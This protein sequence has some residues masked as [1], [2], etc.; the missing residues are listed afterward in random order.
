MSGPDFE[1]ARRYALDRLE[2]ELAATLVYHSLAHTR[3]EV[4]PA[5]EWLAALEGVA[6]EPLL[7][8]LT[9]AYYHDLG[10]VERR[11]GHEAAGARIASQALPAFGYSPAQ[12]RAIAA[13]I[14][15]TEIG[16]NPA[17]HL[18]QILADADLDVLGREDFEERNRDLR[19]EL[20]AHGQV[21]SDEEWFEGQ[22]AL[23]ETHRYFTASA[24]AVRDQ[25]KQRNLS[26]IRTLLRQCRPPSLQAG[27]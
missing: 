27:P 21:F 22:L 3:D 20:A 15:A 25:G 12:V 13:M 2:R 8:L 1:Q 6:G 19:A 17:T 23:L 18:E 7:L 5:A 24:R 26:Y 9:A 14:L 10:F 4:V 16:R 11:A